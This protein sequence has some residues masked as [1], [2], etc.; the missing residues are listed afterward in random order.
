[1]QKIN[2]MSHARASFFAR[3]RQ[4]SI[5]VMIAVTL[6]G[7][8]QR[9]TCPMS[10]LPFPSKEPNERTKQLSAADLMAKKIPI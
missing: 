10:I 3:V 4:L 5:S 6:D 7:S 1:M 2:E 9:K 8:E